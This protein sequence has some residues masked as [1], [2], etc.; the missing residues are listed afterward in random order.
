MSSFH[1]LTPAGR[2]YALAHI[3]ESIL[4]RVALME[5]QGDAEDWPPHYAETAVKLMNYKGAEQ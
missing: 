3:N 4:A 2:A 1:E 5:D